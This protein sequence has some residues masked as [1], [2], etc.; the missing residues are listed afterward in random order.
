ML[1]RTKHYVSRIDKVVVVSDHSEQQ[2]GDDVKRRCAWVTPNTGDSLAHSNRD[3][4]FNFDSICFFV[5][6]IY[7]IDSISVYVTVKKILKC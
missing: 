7:L 3:F 1:S 6:F 4:L 5:S 2:D